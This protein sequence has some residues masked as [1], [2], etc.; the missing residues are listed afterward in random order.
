MSGE[1][2]KKTI[3]G[4]SRRQFMAAASGAAVLFAIGGFSCLPKDEKF[5]LPKLPYPENALEPIISANTVGFHY[6]KHHAGYV[7]KLNTLVSRTPYARM[8]LEKIIAETARIPDKAPIFNNAAQAWNHTFYWNCLNPQ[9][10]GEPPAEFKAV[11]EKSFGSVE[12]CKKEL[13]DAATSQFGSGWAWLV[14]DGEKLAATSTSNA[15]NPIAQG[16]RPI[17]TID[18]WEHAYYLDHQNRRAEYVSGVI[19]K[20]LDWNFA[21]DNLK[22]G[23]ETKAEKA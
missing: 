18:V 8:P 3:A 4:I 2:E 15:D 20:L 12:K 11:V 14:F 13:A 23:T 1:N 5:A 16:L 22:G 17:L 21:A 9:G 10:G 6:G 7:N 19:D